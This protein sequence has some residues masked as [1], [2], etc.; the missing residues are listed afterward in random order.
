M[1]NGPADDA[2]PADFARRVTE[3]DRGAIVRRIEVGCDR[4]SA[5]MQGAY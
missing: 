1:A 2:A 4:T 3:R 5:A